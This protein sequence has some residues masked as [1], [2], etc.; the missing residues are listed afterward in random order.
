MKL[1]AAAIVLTCLMAACGSEDSLPTP[2]LSA[3]DATETPTTTASP[4]K[5][6]T[7]V[8]TSTPTADA[9]S[10]PSPEP[11]PPPAAT[12]TAV[13][14]TASGIEGVALVGPSCP[15][16]QAG[17]PCPDKLWE[18]VAA[19]E[20]LSGRQVTRTTTDAE[21]R[22]SIELPPGEYVLVTLTDGFLPAP[23]NLTITVVA[24]QVTHAELLL[25]SGIR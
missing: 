4:E 22:F 21:G 15:V 2:T 17:V 1:L 11:T 16:Q 24:D 18:G 5:S 6:A 9:T 7:P 13:V 10:T 25:D 8:L 3:A 23:A 12:P 19:V 14:S 20:D